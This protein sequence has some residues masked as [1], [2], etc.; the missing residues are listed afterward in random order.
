MELEGKLII[1]SSHQDYVYALLTGYVD[2]PPGVVVAE[3]M[4]YN[5]CVSQVGALS[6]KILATLICR[7]FILQ[8]LPGWWYCHGSSFV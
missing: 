5:P 3:S 6:L 7:S 2:P 8:V 1:V 4:N